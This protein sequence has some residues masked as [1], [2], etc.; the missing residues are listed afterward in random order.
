MKESQHGFEIQVEIPKGFMNCGVTT[1]NYFVSDTNDSANW[2]TLKFPLPKPPT[3]RGWSIMQYNE[4]YDH[5]VVVD[6][7]CYKG[8]LNP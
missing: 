6:L 1:N 3:G 7:I 8:I 5:K 4:N 2:K